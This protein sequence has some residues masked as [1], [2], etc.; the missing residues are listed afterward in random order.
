MKTLFKNDKYRKSRGGYSRILEIHC[1]QCGKYVLTYQKD[2]IGALKRLYLDRIIA[3]E[4]LA[5]LQN[6]ELKAIPNL[7]CSLCDSHIGSPYIYEKESRKAY[8]LNHGS[9]SKV[10]SKMI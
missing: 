2:G 10:I 6:Q 9:I 4:T 7:R 5:E 1:S 3:P 8:I